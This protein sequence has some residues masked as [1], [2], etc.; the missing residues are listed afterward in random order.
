MHKLPKAAVVIA[1]LGTVGLLGAGL[2]AAAPAHADGGPS[3]SLLDLL[4]GSSCR[5]HDLGTDVLGEVGV[6]GG[7]QTTALG[8]SMGCNTLIS[9]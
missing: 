1:A 3:G 8:S 9:K 4:Q 2:L 7:L 6:V 5:S